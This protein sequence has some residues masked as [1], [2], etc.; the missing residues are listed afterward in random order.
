MAAV[1][2]PQSQP[3]A[4]GVTPVW[5]LKKQIAA[6]VEQSKRLTPLIEQVKIKEW[7]A[8]AG[9]AYREQHAAVRQEVEYLARAASALAEEPEKMP[10]ALDSFL[11]L[12][13]LE[14]TLDSL[15]E[16]VRRYQNPA[17]A[18]LIQGTI[19]E[20]GTHRNRLQAYLIELVATKHDELRVATEEAQACRATQLRI[21]PAPRAP[22]RPVSAAPAV[23]RP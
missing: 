22:S 13:T 5:E 10:L 9:Q 20:N 23:R 17:L 8:E 7:P 18:D 12:N 19:S 2:Q 15:S 1:A 21:A 11:R 14:R 4:P 3:N 16:G 6:L